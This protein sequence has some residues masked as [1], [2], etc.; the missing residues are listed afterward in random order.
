MNSNTTVEESVKQEDSQEQKTDLSKL[1]AKV[2]AS[3]MLILKVCSIGA[4]VGLIVALGTPKE[5]TAKILIIPERTSRSSSSRANALAAMMGG[6]TAS[7]DAIYP[8]LYPAIVKS[9]PFL[10]RLFDVEVR[11][12]KDS[13]AI[14]LAQ[15]LKERQKSPWWNAITSAP[16]RLVG[17]GIS[18][19]R[20]E[21]NETQE[22]AQKR[23][24]PFQLTPGEASIA[25]AIASKIFI[26]YD[27]KKRAVTL[28]VTVQNP[29][30]AATVADTVSAHLQAYIT[31]YRT[32][33]ARTILNYNEKLCQEAQAEYYKAQEKQAAY[34]DA[35]RNLVLRTSRAQLANLQNETNLALNAYNRLE[36]QVQLAKTKVREAIP[37]YV[38]IQPA[39]VPPAPS[40]PH[41]VQILAIYIL[42]SGAAAVGWVLFGKDFLREIKDKKKATAMQAEESK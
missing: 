17:L 42:L 23:I 35:N 24:D 34:A 25:G 28:L 11:E 19:F 1:F 7:R 4:V 2:W 20:E 5:Y 22:E 26:E 16:S 32:S 3:R 10:I 38:V 39:I 30:V 33:K 27:K 6:S 13:T 29:L 15:Y 41:M 9:T 31:E 21:E 40:K 12:Q 37:A 8:S 18:L 36:Q 14:T